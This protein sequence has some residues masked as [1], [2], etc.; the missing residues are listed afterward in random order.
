MLRY[1]EVNSKWKSSGKVALD[2]VA[3]ASIWG[4]RALAA[5]KRIGLNIATD[6]LFTM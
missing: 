3:E 1:N 6:P 5:I 2:I 4:A